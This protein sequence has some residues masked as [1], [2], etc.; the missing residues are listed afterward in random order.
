M[1]LHT[2]NTG[3]L[4]L[5]QEV[6]WHRGADTLHRIQIEQDSRLCMDF[7][8]IIVIRKQLAGFNSTLHR[9]SVHYHSPCLSCT[10]V[11]EQEIMR[12]TRCRLPGT[13]TSIVES[14]ARTLD[15][16]RSIPNGF[17]P[18]CRHRAIK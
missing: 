13:S 10:S 15:M 4:K 9:P 1:P 7:R 17:A 18:C 8:R 12:P 14:V 5:P 2:V 11:S 3:L 16:S 6:F